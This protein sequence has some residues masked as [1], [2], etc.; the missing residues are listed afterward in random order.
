MDLFKLI[1]DPK[2]LS[3]LGPLGLAAIVEGYWLMQ[4]FK[5]YDGVQEKRL[6]EN[7]QM[8]K[9]YMELST[10][11]NKTLDLLIKAFQKNNGNGGNGNG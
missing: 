5:K 9:E 3:I 2:V 7:K 6:D 8:Q 10:D 4:L 11:I 1:L